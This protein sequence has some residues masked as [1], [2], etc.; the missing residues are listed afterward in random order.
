MVPLGMPVWLRVKPKWPSEHDV[1]GGS[2]ADEVHVAVGVD[3]AGFEVVV[4][5]FGRGGVLLGPGA[6]AVVFVDVVA[7]SGAEGLGDE[8]EE[9]VV[10]E[11]GEVGGAHAVGFA[12]GAKSGGPGGPGGAGAV[13]EGGADEGVA[14]ADGAVVVVDAPGDVGVAVEVEVADGT[15]AVAEV[16][17]LVDGPGSGAVAEPG[18]DA[19][20]L[21]V[22][23]GVAVVA[24]AE[25]V[26]VTVLV[27]VCEFD[28]HGAAVEGGVI[29]AGGFGDEGE[30][31]GGLGGLG[32][33]VL[34]GGNRGK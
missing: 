28:F 19:V 32:Y 24:D 18:H 4:G 13:A 7:V 9:A 33:G 25:D 21:G 29:E 2:G 1:G 27:D 15:A 14:V 30:L 8:V 26:E 11:V 10:V 17:V 5:V 6:V 31:V 23:V 34:V 20:F 3:V 22:D 16:S 12:A